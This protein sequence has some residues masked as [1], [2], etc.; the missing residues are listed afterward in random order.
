M[1]DD[2]PDGA[3]PLDPD[4]R[5]G[6][7]IDVVTTMGQLNE[8]EQANIL[9]ASAWLRRQRK[10]PPIQLLTRDFVYELH[11]Q[12]FGDVWTWAG[13]QRQL[14]IGFGVDPLEI[15]VRLK[16]L[17]DDAT[18]WINNGTYEPLELATKLHHQLVYI[19]PF[20]NGNGRHARLFTD[21]I[22]QRLLGE[23]PISWSGDRSE[24]IN[25]LRSADGGN[26]TP[27]IAWITA[28]R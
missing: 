24:Y 25:A 4:Q 27:L 9:S 23:P 2:Q 17:L 8:L 15:P 22:L 5:E 16:N 11:K 21:T 13:T 26:L 1:W 3:T 7:K 18:Y 28:H 6:L 20:P 10:F 14:E 12:M 19:H